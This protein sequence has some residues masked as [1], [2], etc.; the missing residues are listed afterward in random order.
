MAA[1]ALASY[2]AVVAWTR[3]AVPPA[4]YDARS[5]P[6]VVARANLIVK[7]KK[8]RDYVVAGEAAGRAQGTCA[9]SEGETYAVTLEAPPNGAVVCTCV[10]RGRARGR[11][12]ARARDAS[13]FRAGASAGLALER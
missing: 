13:S 12:R 10:A 2:D 5:T 11:G 3:P 4:G 1:P 8:L 6:Q 9:G 7:E